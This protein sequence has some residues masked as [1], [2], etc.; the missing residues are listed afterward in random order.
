MAFETEIGTLDFE[1][2]TEHALELTD[3]EL[4]WARNDARATAEL[5]DQATGAE[6]I[7]D[8]AG[9]YRDEATVY[10]REQQRRRVARVNAAIR[11]EKVRA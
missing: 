4:G 6:G 8:L 11:D 2:C 3:V 5:W 9:K 10:G 7:A 1:R